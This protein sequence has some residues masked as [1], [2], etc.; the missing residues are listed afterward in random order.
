MSK[1]IANKI[2]SMIKEEITRL[3]LVKS[4]KMRDSIKVTYSNNNY[5]IEAIEYFIYK[6]KEFGITEKVFNSDE[7]LSFIKQEIINQ[8]YKDINI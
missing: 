3:G 5:K 6:D 7:L 1:E 4:G 2:E 8:I